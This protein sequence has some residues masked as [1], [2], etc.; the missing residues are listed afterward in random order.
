MSRS[1]HIVLKPHETKNRKLLE[2]PIPPG[3]AD[4]VEEY[5]QKFRPALADSACPYLFPGGNRCGCAS[6]GSVSTNIVKAVAREAGVRI[7]VHLLR[8]FAAY[9]YLKRHPG[10]YG[11][12]AKI[13]GHKNVATTVSFYDAFEEAAAAKAFDA[14][15]DAER[16]ATR[17]T[18]VAARSRRAPR[19]APTS[20]RRA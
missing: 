11:V 10:R 2:W 14:V 18:A 1:P 13:L 5:V 8:H 4:L 7:N 15:L 19:Q 6:Q 16:R 9:L 17:V 20:R 3:A 12:V